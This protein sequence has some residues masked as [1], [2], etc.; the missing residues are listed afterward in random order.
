MPGLLSIQ[1]VCRFILFINHNEDVQVNIRSW[2][3]AHQMH[4]DISDVS[5]IRT[6]L[7]KFWWTSDI[8]LLG[9]PQCY[10][11]SANYKEHMIRPTADSY[12]SLFCHWQKTAIP[13]R[14]HCHTGYITCPHVW[15]FKNSWFPTIITYVIMYNVWL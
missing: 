15:S 4:S 7:I 3:D 6:D 9:H 10:D 8:Y 14:Q 13:Y 12:F 2:S 11:Q 1:M 5:N